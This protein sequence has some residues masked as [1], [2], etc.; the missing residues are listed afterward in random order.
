MWEDMTPWHAAWAEHAKKQACSHHRA[1]PTWMILRKLAPLE[2][3]AGT[4]EI[5]A[6]SAQKYQASG[7]V[8]LLQADLDLPNGK[9][10]AVADVYRYDFDGHAL[11]PI[12]L[13]L[14]TL[15]ATKTVSDDLSK[16]VYQ[17]IGQVERGWRQSNQ[18]LLTSA[19][20]VCRCRRRDAGRFGRKYKTKPRHATPV[21]GAHVVT[22]TRDRSCRR[23]RISR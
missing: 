6:P 5:F 2:A 17:I 23:D 15:A 14:P 12:H 3:L 18:A 8:A 13:K 21:A 11:E 7:V 20:L 16:G 19:F 10:E 22:M 9:S 1:L 4:Q